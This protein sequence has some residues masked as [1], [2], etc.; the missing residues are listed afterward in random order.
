MLFETFRSLSGYLSYDVHQNLVFPEH[1][2]SSLEFFYLTR[3]S[4][5]CRVAGQEYDLQ[6]GDALL[7]LPYEIHSYVEAR[8]SVGK[9]F[10]FSPDLVPEFGS[11]IRSACLA[12]P[13][14]TPDPTL[15]ED[16]SEG[17]S[18]LRRIG[19][20]YLL[21]DEAVRQNGLIPSVPGDA[22]LTRRVAAY[23]DANYAGAITLRTMAQELGY[24]YNYLS[25]FIN[26]TFSCSFT[27]L[28]NR[29]RVS[30]AVM[31]L[32]TTGHSVTE[33]SALCG[34]G[35]TRSMDRAFQKTL[36]MS[37]REAA[38]SPLPIFHTLEGLTP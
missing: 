19:R 6:A 38:L 36:G 33:I 25:S 27:D 21:C 9:M 15:M 3:G 7:I 1:I 8:G 24:H 20:L 12:S 35:S 23:M 31:L 2:H 5:L 17:D 28:V 16:A 14:F 30:R 34:F 37:P 26:D 4:V 29:F 32:R 11:L 13:L 10:I 22:Q 18:R